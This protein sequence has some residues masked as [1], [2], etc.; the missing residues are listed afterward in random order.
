MTSFI[1]ATKTIREWMAGGCVATADLARELSEWALWALADGGEPTHEIIPTI[2]ADRLRAI[3]TAARYLMA[4]PNRTVEENASSVL[5]CA[6]KLCGPD[7]CR[8][9]ADEVTQ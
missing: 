3:E 1:A 5:Y 7:G 4:A 2:E 8:D 9:C 6:L